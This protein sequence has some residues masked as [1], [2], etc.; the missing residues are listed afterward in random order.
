MISYSHSG[1]T[2]DVFSSLAVVRAIGSGDYYLRL[3]NLDN[4]C[5]DIGWGNAGR[6]SGRMTQQDFEFL[7]PIMEIQ[8][9]INKFAVYTGEEISHLLEKR[10]YHLNCEAWPRNFANQD[11]VAM[12]LDMDQHFRTL[13]IDPYVEVDKPTVVP[14]RPICISRNP[15]YLEGTE[16]ITQVPE[17]V[18]WIERNLMDQAFFVGTP[19]DHEWFEDTMK[20]KVVHKPTS[21]GLELA[22]YIA[23]AKMM[24]GNQSMPATLAVGIGTTLWIET[25]KN[26]PLDN[27]EIL[28]PY[29][30]NITYF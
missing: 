24:I 27:N 20:V 26:T 6:H 8:S 2:G 12:E 15:H 18:N 16:D 14:G 28:Y 13:Q 29:R 17:W 10:A 30:S 4:I 7:A 9:C 25:R 19:A 21:D 1:T 5:R 23:G 3:N 11:A 22:R